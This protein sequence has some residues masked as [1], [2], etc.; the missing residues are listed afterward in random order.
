MA[1]TKKVLEYQKFIKSDLANDE[2]LKF[3]KENQ[4]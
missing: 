1:T 3:S 2:D 4:E